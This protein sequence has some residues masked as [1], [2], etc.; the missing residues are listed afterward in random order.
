MDYQ[1]L[2]KEISYA[3]RH[4]PWEYELEL[5]DKGFASI[6]QLLLALNEGLNYKRPIV[7]ADLHEVIRSSDKRRHEIVDMKIRA[8]YGH[9]IPK[10]I[11]RVAEEPPEALFHG[12]ASRFCE[13]I[14]SEG[15]KPLTRQYVHLSVD[16]DTAKRVGSRKDS[17]PTILEV[18]AR[19]AFEDGLAFYQGNDIV[20]LAEEIPPKY[21]R[22]IE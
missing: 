17:T 15:L 11:L 2:S 22:L 18:D 10:K 1:K 9:T 13:A 5:D 14:M 6:G 7:E 8:L 3:L 19:K 12:T 20:W 21:L 4:A 16:I